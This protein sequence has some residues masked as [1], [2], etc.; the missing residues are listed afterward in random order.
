[1]WLDDVRDLIPARIGAMP[2]LPGAALGKAGDYCI[3][4]QDSVPFAEYLG[5]SELRRGGVIYGWEWMA[6]AAVAAV[7]VAASF[8]GI[9]LI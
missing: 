9:F 3:G 6:L 4:G 2:G 7:T 1:M 5:N 8:I